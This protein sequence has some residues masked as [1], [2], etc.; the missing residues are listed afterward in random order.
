[1]IM[2]RLAGLTALFITVVAALA[3]IASAG[4]KICRR[5]GTLARFPDT[6]NESRLLLPRLRRAGP[7]GIE[8]PDCWSVFRRVGLCQYSRL[9]GCGVGGLGG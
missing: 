7:S 9:R 3:P 1:M 5:R 8:K 6:D 4:E 2:T